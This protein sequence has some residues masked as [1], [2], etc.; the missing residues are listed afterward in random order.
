MR[1]LV[2][3]ALLLVALPATAL[4]QQA[5]DLEAGVPIRIRARAVPGRIV[6]TLLGV[7]GDTV[8]VA[9]TADTLHIP[10]STL[11]RAEVNFRGGFRFQRGVR[12]AAL[13]FG[14]GLLITA[15]TISDIEDNPGAYGTL[16]VGAH[17][18]LGFLSQG[19]G[20]NARTGSLIG[21]GVGIP[22]GI[23]IATRNY[24]PCT[25]GSFLCFDEGF[26][27]M[28]GTMAGAAIGGMTG[29]L[30]G[31][32]IPGDHWEKVSKDRLRLTVNP[33]VEGGIEVGARLRF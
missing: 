22:I 21:A 30:V 4:A 17:T 27:V 20:T 8:V 15:L 6:G 32:F 33:R 14:S 26:Y 9:R 25:P 11:R 13:G 18:L 31:A 24:E 1:Q 7:H 10:L 29:M 5:A 19:G 28:I 12:G 16:T 3:L 2:P 23:A